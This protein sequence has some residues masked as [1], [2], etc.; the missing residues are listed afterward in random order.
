MATLS[1]DDQ[2]EYGPDN[3]NQVGSWMMLSVI[4]VCGIIW[5]LSNIMGA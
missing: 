5:K 1:G 3:C 4:F 2:I